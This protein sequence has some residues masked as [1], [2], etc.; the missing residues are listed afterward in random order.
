MCTIILTVDKEEQ[1][2]VLRHKSILETQ[3]S[4]RERDEQIT[5]TFRDADECAR[6][7]LLVNLNNNEV[8]G[9]I[10]IFVFYASL[11]GR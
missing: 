10:T 4:R 11:K 2:H 7:K 6:W 3:Q 5:V 8:V 1:S 9:V